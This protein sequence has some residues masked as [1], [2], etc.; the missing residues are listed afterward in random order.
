MHG[1][2]WRAVP[3]EFVNTVLMN[4]HKVATYT[5]LKDR[6]LTWAGGNLDWELI[7]NASNHTPMELGNASSEPNAG[8]GDR[9]D[10]VSKLLAGITSVQKET[11]SLL[12]AMVKGKGR[13]GGGDVR[14]GGTNGKGTPQGPRTDGKGPGKGPG[15]KQMVTLPNGVRIPSQRLRICR[16]FAKGKCQRRHCTFPHVTGLP[17]S[18]QEKALSPQGLTLASLGC[19]DAQ[20]QDGTY[21]FDA[22]KERQVLAALNAGSSASRAEAGAAGAISS[23]DAWNIEGMDEASMQ[24]LTSS[25]PF[26]GPED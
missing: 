19:E 8:H 10:I 4:G 11:N 1:F 20:G 26:G 12:A 13:P 25:H 18:L 23:E 14:M 7:Q 5:E 21:A 2:L 6:L 16:D 15:E 24:A 17:A 22:A 3:Q 9:D